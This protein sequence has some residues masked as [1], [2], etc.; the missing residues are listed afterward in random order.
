[1]SFYGWMAFAV[2]TLFSFFFFFLSFSLC[3]VPFVIQSQLSIVHCPL[4][5]AHCPL[6]VCLI[7][8]FVHCT[9]FIQPIPFSFSHN[10]ARLVNNIN[11][12]NNTTT[13]NPFCLSVPTACL[14]DCLD[15]TLPQT[16]HISHNISKQNPLPTRT[17]TNAIVHTQT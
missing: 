10:A 6:F 16:N 1:M 11:T 8:S 13:T 4:S 17:K 9:S 3:F 5:I 15:H 14:L 12:N 7:V 2:L